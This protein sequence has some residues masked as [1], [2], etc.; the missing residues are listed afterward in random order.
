MSPWCSPGFT[1]REIHGKLGLRGQATAE[2]FLDEARVPDTLRIADEGAGFTIAMT[3]LNK[4]RVSVAAGS[5]GLTRA[6]LEAS[7]SHAADRE[8]FGRPIAG[9]QLIQ[10]L[11][12]DMA[13]D[14]DAARLLVWRCAEPIDAGQPFATEAS[15][16]T[17]FASEAAVTAANSAIQIFGGYGYIDEYPVGK[18]LRDA[19]V[20]TLYEGT[21]QIQRLLIGRALTG[22]SAIS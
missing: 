1:S 21:S 10:E 5:V 3:A 7:V 6:C 12:A 20:T 19:R 8:Q 11:L 9:F 16:A 2:L 4:G 15:I 14:T 13:V 18:Y 22:V 17:L